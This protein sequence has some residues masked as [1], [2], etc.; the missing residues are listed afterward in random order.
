MN[1]LINFLIQYGSVI[2]LGCHFFHSDPESGLV[3]ENS[4]GNAHGPIE[5]VLA[6][7]GVQ[8]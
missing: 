6:V 3:R 8:L 2:F 7:V 1:G 5:A 4:A